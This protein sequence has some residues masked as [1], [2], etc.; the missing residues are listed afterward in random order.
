MC[1]C[2]KNDVTGPS[3]IVVVT[4]TIIYEGVLYGSPTFDGFVTIQNG[5]GLVSDATATVNGVVFTC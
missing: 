2:A 5:I 4:E 1:G 3:S